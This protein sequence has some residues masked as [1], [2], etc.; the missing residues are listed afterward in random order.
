MTSPGPLGVLFVSADRRTQDALAFLLAE[1]CKFLSA[2]TLA[3]AHDLAGEGVDLILCDQQLPD[4]PGLELLEKLKRENHPAFRIIVIGVGQ[5]PSL[6]RALAQGVANFSLNRP[7]RDSD[8]D[9]VLALVG[10][11]NQL[12]R[13][14][15]ELLDHLERMGTDI[16]TTQA[17]FRRLIEHLPEGILVTD[18]GGRILLANHQAEKALGSEAQALV[19]LTVAKLFKLEWPAGDGPQP[20]VMPARLDQGNAASHPIVVT[21]APITDLPEQPRLVFFA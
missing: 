20:V 9:M 5:P 3:L 12:R 16:D 4:G 1:R 19:G 10:E 15:H 8:L 7:L 6:R 18:R 21:I 11:R 13:Q 2:N 14:N 17:M